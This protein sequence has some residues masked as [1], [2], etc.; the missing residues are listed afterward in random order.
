LVLCA[1]L[2]VANRAANLASVSCAIS[3]DVGL[4]QIPWPAA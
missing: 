2:N 3:K 4:P 1:A